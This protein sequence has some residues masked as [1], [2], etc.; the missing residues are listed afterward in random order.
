[1]L[2]YRQ[3]LHQAAGEGVDPV[4]GGEDPV[5]GGE[6]VAGVNPVAVVDIVAGVDVV[7]GVDAAAGVD[8][9][10]GDPSSAGAGAAGFFMLMLWPCN[11]NGVRHMAQQSGVASWTGVV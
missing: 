3:T 11:G 9:A 10:A 4:A 7:A 5:A 2:R 8:E 1:M 6:L